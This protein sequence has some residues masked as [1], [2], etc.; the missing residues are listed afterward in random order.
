MSKLIKTIDQSNRF[1]LVITETAFD[2]IDG[3]PTALLHF[4]NGT[5]HKQPVRRGAL[6]GDGDSNTKLQKN[7]KRGFATAG[8]SLSP[9]KSSGFNVCAYASP[10]CIAACLDVTGLGAVFQRIH[11][12]RIAKTVFWNIARH[13]A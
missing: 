3:V 4:N 12:A 11:W 13:V 7:S 8:L 5:I 10:G 1:E 2:V 9:H 6:L